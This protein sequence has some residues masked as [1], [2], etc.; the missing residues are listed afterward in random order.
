MI[1]PSVECISGKIGGDETHP[2]IGVPEYSRFGKIETGAAGYG[3]LK[4]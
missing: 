1:G 4:P 3:L 2:R